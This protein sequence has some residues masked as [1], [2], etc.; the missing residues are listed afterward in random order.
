MSHFSKIDKDNIVTEVIV[1]E[2]DFI[3]SGAIPEMAGNTAIIV[4]PEHGRNDKPNGIIDG[5]QF[6]AYDHSDMNSRRIFG[7][8]AGPNIPVGEE[9]NNFDDVT[10]P[11]GDIVNVPATIAE[12]LGFKQELRD[13]GLIAS[14]GRDSLLDL[15]YQT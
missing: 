8:M 2:Q 10:N 6:R 13:S 11:I 4:M 9:T 14:K 12:I 7:L 1:A 15:Y 3:N 5:N